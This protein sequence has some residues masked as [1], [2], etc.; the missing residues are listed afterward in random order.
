MPGMPHP[1]PFP[2]PFPFPPTKR[3]KEPPRPGRRTD[4]SPRVSPI[5]CG[6][7]TRPEATAASRGPP[8]SV[9]CNNIIFYIEV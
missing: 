1:P 4:R 6:A 8:P 5:P 9:P 2:F 7:G 3:A